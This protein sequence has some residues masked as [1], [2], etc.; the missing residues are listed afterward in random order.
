MAGYGIGQIPL[1][2]LNYKGVKST[3]YHFPGIVCSVGIFGDVYLREGLRGQGLGSAAHWHRLQYAKDQ[4]FKYVMCSVRRDNDRQHH[5]LKKFG[6]KE[7]GQT[8]TYCHAIVMY[9]RHLDDIRLD[10]PIQ[11]EIE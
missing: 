7:I 11:S 8:D 10:G 1:Y 5:I 4:G 9:E 6:W 3:I 2:T